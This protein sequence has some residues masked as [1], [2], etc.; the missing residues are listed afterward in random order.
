MCVHFWRLSWTEHLRIINIFCNNRKTNG[1][2]LLG[3]CWGNQ[4][5]Q[6]PGCPTKM[7]SLQHF[8]WVTVWNLHY[9]SCL[10]YQSVLFHT[11]AIGTI[12][13]FNITLILLESLSDCTVSLTYSTPSTNIYIYIYFYISG[14]FFNIFCWL[15]NFK[16][17][18][19]CIK[20]SPVRAIPFKLD[21]Q[22][23][24]RR[25]R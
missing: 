12:F 10:L 25:K 1:K 23:N 6:L 17:V 11:I 24:S 16:Q 2:C 22:L 19:H 20:S 14:I 8:I 15:A 21:K 9:L 5:C 18:K 4:G 3:F 7:S 13:S